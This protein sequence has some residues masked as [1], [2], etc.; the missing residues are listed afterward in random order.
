MHLCFVFREGLD[1]HHSLIWGH[2]HCPPLA[3]SLRPQLLLVYFLSCW[4]TCSGHVVQTE[5]CNVLCLAFPH[6]PS[7]FMVC[8]YWSMAH[9]LLLG[10]SHSSACMLHV[11]LPTSDGQADCSHLGECSCVK[12]WHGPHAFIPLGCTMELLGHVAVLLSFLS[13]LA[14]TI[15]FPVPSSMCGVGIAPCPCRYFL[16]L[17]SWF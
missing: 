16:C 9:A 1:D 6:L 12:C 8:R 13:S 7:I 5:S 4:F 14:W 2:C 15:Y 11:L 3:H 10:W 17:L